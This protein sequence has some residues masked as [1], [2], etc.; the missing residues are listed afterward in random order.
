MEIQ[1]FNAQE[2]KELKMKYKAFFSD[3]SNIS[4]DM[5]PMLEKREGR[6]LEQDQAH[7]GTLLVMGGGGGGGRERRGEER[8]GE[9]RRGEERRGEERRNII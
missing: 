9:E 4:F 1:Y 6:N 2:M 3:R 8:R 5:H 7:V